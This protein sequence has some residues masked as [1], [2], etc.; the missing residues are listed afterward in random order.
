MRSNLKEDI[1][2]FKKQ[3]KTYLFVI[4]ILTISITLLLLPTIFEI[5]KYP[6]RSFT[7]EQYIDFL[8]ITLSF[9]LILYLSKTVLSLKKKYRFL[10]KE[11]K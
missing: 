1:Q 7:W 9:L 5:I 3:C 2:S 8:S 6:D 10:E 4:V 11:D